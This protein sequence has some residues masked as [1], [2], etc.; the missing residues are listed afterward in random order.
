MTVEWMAENGSAGSLVNS[1]GGDIPR[2][3]KNAR[4]KYLSYEDLFGEGRKDK[5]YRAM[6]D[7]NNPLNCALPGY[8][9]SQ[10]DINSGWLPRDHSPEGYV[11]IETTRAIRKGEQL[12]VDYGPSY[13]EDSEAKRVGM[14]Q[15]D[16]DGLR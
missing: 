14:L 15:R 5:A 2:K 10:R 11:F 13:F 16:P 12:F 6:A 4:Y 8:D 1:V 9:P 7:W 3:S